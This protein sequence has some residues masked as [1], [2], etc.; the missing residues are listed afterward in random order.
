M[1]STKSRFILAILLG[2]AAVAGLIIYAANQDVPV[3]MPK[4]T[5]ADSQFRLIIFSL[6]LSLIV[7][8]PVFLL[9]AYF[10][11][12][13]RE[14]NTKSEYKPDLDGNTALELIWWGIPAAL[15][16]IIGIMIWHSSYAL[17]PYKK[18]DNQ[19]PLKIQ[20]VALDWKW[21]FIYPEYNT[22]SLN[23]FKFPQNRPVQFD[24]TSDGPMNSFWIPSLGGQI[25]AMPGMSTR[26]NLKA[27]T[28]DDFRGSSA[29]LSGR[30]FSSM[31]FDADST[32]DYEFNSWVK[33]TER[34]GEPLGISAYNDLSAQKRDKRRIVYTNVPSDL[35]DRVIMKYMQP[36]Q[37]DIEGKK[38]PE[39]SL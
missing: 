13:Y 4:G 6:L 23:Y 9:T 10:A 25:Y 20:V 29:N 16:L 36:A 33:R 17:D 24:I 18:L 19:Q 32:S 3:L 8:V 22:A 26:L 31:T 30:G 38:R 7:L 11:I 1:R 14:S 35:Y 5:I 34:Y 12:K 28:Y 15:I 2:V 27:N 39:L 21:L 37:N